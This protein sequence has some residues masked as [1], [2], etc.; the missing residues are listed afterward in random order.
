MNQ[1]VN[2]NMVT[3]AR[4][5]RGLTQKDL[6]ELLE[7]TQGRVSKIEQGL[8][9]VP[10]DLLEKISDTL[11][12]PKAF[13]FE[14]GHIY[15]SISPFHRKRKSL[16]KKVLNKIE[17]E[18]NIRRIHVMKFLQGAEVESKI[19]SQ[20]LDDYDVTP[21]E[22]AQQIRHYWRIPMGPINNVCK[23]LEDA[24]IIV[25]HCDFQTPLIDGFSFWVEGIP[26]LIF[27]NANMP[28][29]R[30]RFTVAHELGHIIMHRVPTPTM[31]DEAN[32]FAS[33]LLMPEDEIK[34]Y[35]SSLSLKKLANLKSYW[36]VSMAALIQRAGMLNTMG[37]NQIRYLWM[38]MSKAGYR[39]RE[40]INIEK[41]KPSLIREIVDLHL[42]VLNYSRAEL[43]RMLAC[44]K[45]EFVRLYSDGNLTLV[46]S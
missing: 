35:L 4:N 32:K 36:K 12:Y 27:A 20:D 25:F 21:E 46:K 18:A 5:S 30:L 34:P 13:F 24:G 45:D 26:P 10:E 33:E 43:C 3:L 29:D 38:Q 41:E 23:V 14:P 31:E 2:H 11:D 7:V 15:P 39:R 44:T 1:N 17:A 37:R 16:P 28:G 42:N 40:P 9:L 6:S 22:T 8:L 19:I